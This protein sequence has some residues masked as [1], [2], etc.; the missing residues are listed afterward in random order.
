M[1][2]RLQPR[3]TRVDVA[4]ILAFAAVCVYALLTVRNGFFFADESFYITMAER[5]V[6]GDRPLVDEWHISQ[7]FGLLL[8]LPYKAFVAIRGSTDGILLF[9]RCLFLT[10]NAAFYW[11]M[12]LRLR[13]YGWI[14]LVAT[15]LFCA[16]IP[17]G[18]AA[19]NYYTVSIRLLMIVCLIL[20]S[21]KQKP[22]SLL[23][24]GL[25]FACAVLAQ[26]GFV[27]LYLVY[28]VLVWT[29]FLRQKKGRDFLE[30]CAGCFR[31]RAWVYLTLT[32]LVC[33]GVVIAWLL[34]KSGLRNIL[35]SVQNLFADPEHD[36]ASLFIAVTGKGFLYRKIRDAILFYGL[37]CV[38]PALAVVILSAVYARGV[39]R[40]R[41]ET[42]RKILF[43]AACAVWIASCVPCFRISES[44][45]RDVFF[46][47]YPA[48]LFWF[49]FV[50]FLLCRQKNKRLLFFWCAG[51]LASL[52]ID[53]LSNITLFAGTPIALIASLVFFTDLVRE[54]CTERSD[55]TG[56]AERSHKRAKGAVLMRAL[57]ALTC[58]CFAA[59]FAFIAIV[60]SNTAFGE[61]FLYGTS[62]FSLPYR[63]E[64]G[65]CRS[66]RCS[67]VVGKYYE[68]QLADLDVIQSKNVKNIYIC[69]LAPE[70]Y[71]YA[72]LPYATYSA[73]SW[74]SESFLARHVRYWTLHPERRPACIY[75]PIDERY[76][77]P[78]D[79]DYGIGDFDV[80]S[81]DA[82]DP[83]C[84]YEVEKG[85]GGY[86]L[87]ISDWTLDA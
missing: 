50:C 63:C 31:M 2:T 48:P 55:E 58:L 9:M 11:I 83:L 61:H 39:F 15:L 45:T 67:D 4:A 44:M 8:C 26:P 41:R 40:A 68:K 10:F 85:Q 32:A 46:Y 17:R 64:K 37:W 22:L 77:D 87:Y 73:F 78:M 76:N 25:L 70:L 20:F 24:A 30:S 21:E 59:W 56:A 38:I 29:R 43:F 13:A 75:V 35:A 7:L 82:F 81:R 69:G 36:Y 27:L 52:C 5:F 3:F 28:S 19:C 84:T 53:L 1:K 14:D 74:R 72:D 42:V 18:I 33:A 34:A 60:P 16:Y 80:W 6:H 23:L 86:I 47:V 12:Y 79:E 71:L 49:G 51:M 66:L 54:F 62:L 57:T 65:P